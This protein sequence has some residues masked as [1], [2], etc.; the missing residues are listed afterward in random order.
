M[1]RVGHVAALVE[2]LGQQL[3]DRD[4]KKAAQTVGTWDAR[5]RAAIE[6]VFGTAYR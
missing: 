4:V 6:T 3:N 2:S 1:R 5:I